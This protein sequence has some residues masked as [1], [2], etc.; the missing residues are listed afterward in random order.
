[1]EIPMYEGK[2][3]EKIVNQCGGGTNELPYD[4]IKY[5][6]RTHFKA[7]QILEMKDGRVIEVDISEIK[8]VNTTKNG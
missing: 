2:Q 6:Q 3:I 5:L 8:F 7:N 4:V 1:M